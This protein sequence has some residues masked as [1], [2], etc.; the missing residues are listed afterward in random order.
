MLL[1]NDSWGR[2]VNGSIGKIVD[3]AQDRVLVELAEGKVTEVAPHTWEIFH[4]NLNQHSYQLETEVVGKFTQFPMKLAW[5]IT[6]HKSQG[7]TFDK[8]ILDLGKGT[9]AHGQ[10][11]VAL[12]R[13]RSLNGIILKKKVKKSHIIM[14][15]KVINF[16]TKYQYKQSE[17]RCSLENKIKIIKQAIADNKNLELTYLKTS[18]EKSRRAIQPTFIGEM[19]YQGKSFL[20]VKAFCL[21]RNDERVFRV[22]RILEIGG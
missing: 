17:S 5:A 20:G 6:I 1:N 19:Q 2:W 18:D 7:K 12:S 8:V 10:L 22:D 16:V 4:F 11:Y 14:D 15:Y 13:C 3:I 21:K 9:F